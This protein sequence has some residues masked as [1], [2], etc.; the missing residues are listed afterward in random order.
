MLYIVKPSLKYLQ[1]TNITHALPD[2]PTE[3]PTQQFMRRKLTM[4]AAQLALSR[5]ARGKRGT[6]RWGITVIS[7][8]PEGRISDLPWAMRT[9]R[10]R[11]PY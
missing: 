4:R 11:L 7:D 1:H 8:T 3:M 9:G 6:C 2:P 10:Q 5:L